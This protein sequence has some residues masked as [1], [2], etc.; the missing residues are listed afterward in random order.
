MSSSPDTSITQTSSR[1]AIS[2]CPSAACSPAFISPRSRGRG[3]GLSH[4]HLRPA[5][6]VLDVHVVHQ[7]PHQVQAATSRAARS[8]PAPGVGHLDRYRAVAARADERERGPPPRSIRMD[9]GVRARLVGGDRD[10]KPIVGVGAAILEP[11]LQAIADECQ[12]LGLGGNGY[13]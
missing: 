10:R 8:A 9:D 11:V 7:A 3:A 13:V 6:V 4:P 1:Y 12:R 5:L 2:T